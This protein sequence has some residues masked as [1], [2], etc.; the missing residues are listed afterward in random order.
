MTA[1]ASK[2]TL[3]DLNRRVD[4]LAKKSAT[5]APGQAEQIATELGVSVND[6]QARFAA[7][8][9][10]HE[11]GVNANEDGGQRS[12][13]L[14]N[15]TQSGAGFLGQ[16]KVQTSSS[17]VL[18][19]A[20]LKVPGEDAKAIAK[21]WTPMLEQA[22]YINDRIAQGRLSSPA[23]DLEWQAL[24]KLQPNDVDFAKLWT[25]DGADMRAKLLTQ[26]D[27]LG[28][29]LPHAVTAEVGDGVVRT[30]A[31]QALTTHIQEAQFTGHPD[32]AKALAAEYVAKFPQ[33]AMSYWAQNI[34]DGK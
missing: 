27:R 7:Q 12:K 17:P 16:P 5:L 14:R 8:R 19:G 20:N 22:T 25:A 24:A 6:V 21:A 18:K 30:A 31:E 3:L 15:A 33:G 34:A 10:V 26:M 23:A 4:D 9:R 1:I 11:S 29:L 28:S 13:D 2:H 32:Q